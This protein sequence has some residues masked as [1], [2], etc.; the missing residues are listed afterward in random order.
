MK[1]KSAPTY[2]LTDALV[3][4]DEWENFDY[5]LRSEIKELGQI[6]YDKAPLNWKKN[7]LA[8]GYLYH[9]EKLL[10]E[11]LEDWY[12]ARDDIHELKTLIEKY[13]HLKT[14]LLTLRIATIAYRAGTISQMVKAEADKQTNRKR[15]ME[16]WDHI[17]Y[18]A[19]KNVLEK[20]PTPKQ[21]TLGYV[22]LKFDVV[23]KGKPLYDCA[24]AHIGEKDT[25]NG[26]WIKSMIN[27]KSYFF[28]ARSLQ[29]FI[30]EY[31]RVQSKKNNSHE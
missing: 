27:S 16:M 2:Y 6:D 11:K 17:I 1:K 10:H 21:W 5:H 30:D 9:V 29:K 8:Y 3:T 12:D 7:T 31:K 14:F 15:T 28:G 19:V 26:I 13:D 25:K 20:A 22:M 4:S 18:L 23:N 24:T